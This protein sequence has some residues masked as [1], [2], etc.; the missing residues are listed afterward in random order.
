MR[1]VAN[2]VSSLKQCFLFFVCF[3]CISTLGCAFHAE[4]EGNSNSQIHVKVIDDGI[5]LKI[6]QSLLTASGFYTGH[7][8]GKYGQITSSAIVHFQE[9]VGV[10]PIDGRATNKLQQQ[11]Q[12]YLESGVASERIN[13]IH[14]E[15]KRKDQIKQNRIEMQAAIIREREKAEYPCNRLKGDYLAKDW[16][17]ELSAK[18]PIDICFAAQKGS[19]DGMVE[20]VATY[21]K[22][23]EFT[24]MFGS[25]REEGAYRITKYFST[26]LGRRDK[27]TSIKLMSYFME[28]YL[29]TNES[30]SHAFRA[31]YL[32]NISN[33]G[34]DNGALFRLDESDEK[35]VPEDWI[36]QYAEFLTLLSHWYRIEKPS[37]YIDV[38]RS[39]KRLTHSEYD[40][41]RLPSQEMLKFALKSLRDIDN[42]RR[43]EK[44]AWVESAAAVISALA[45]LGQ[46]IPDTPTSEGT[47]WQ[48]PPMNMAEINMWLE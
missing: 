47:G 7:I 24:A 11:L 14:E 27:H 6:I 38:R 21:K 31:N 15:N 25:T 2:M 35:P 29:N 13:A 23:S 46:S 42:K 16:Y 36:S 28:R 43:A 1:V 26:L 12:D 3:L 18:Q 41:F 4:A 32:I 40:E 19:P 8:D 48:Q 22:I 45:A 9:E 30:D 33:L 37:D 10:T 44:Y 39:A 17:S 5:E 34:Y 20:L